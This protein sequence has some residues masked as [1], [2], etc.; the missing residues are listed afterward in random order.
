MVPFYDFVADPQS[1]P[2]STNALGGVE[3]IEDSLANFR[4]HAGAG[5]RHGKHDPH[6]PC[7]PISGFATSHEQ[8]TAGRHGVDRISHQITENLSYLSVKALNRMLGAFPLFDLDV[9]VRQSGLV[10]GKAVTNKVVAER[11]NG[12]RRLPMKTKRLISD[13][14][15]SPQFPLCRLDVLVYL[16]KIVAVFG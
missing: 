3:G 1:Q 14:R 12:I 10:N 8:P 7:S 4:T 13:E 5:I 16:R 9:I 15:D 2:R 11:W 6:I